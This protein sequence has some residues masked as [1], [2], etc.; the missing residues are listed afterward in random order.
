MIAKLTMTVFALV[1]LAATADDSEF[2]R[3]SFRNLTPA[4]R[5]RLAADA[6]AGRGWKAHNDRPAMFV[7]GQFFYGLE[8]SD[9]LHTWYER[10][11]H[12]D[13]SLQD[14]NVR[15][16]RINPQSWKRN[17]EIARDMNLDGF[18]FFPSN[19]GCWD[20]LPRSQMSGGE[21]TILP[22]LHNGDTGKGIEHC[23]GVLERLLKEAP[24]CYRLGDRIVITCYPPMVPPWQGPQLEFWA[25]LKAAAKE[26]FGGDRFCF[27]PY[28]YIFDARDLDRPESDVAF[29]EHTEANVRSALR[30]T[31]GLFYNLTESDWAPESCLR[32][33]HDSIVIPIVKKVMSEPEFKDKYLGIGYWQAHE[34]CYRRFAD[35]LSYGF[36]RLVSALRSIEAA[37]PDFAIAFEWD[38]ENENTHFRPTVSNGQ[39]TQRILR[40]CADRWAGTK[41]KPYPTD[42]ATDV[43]NLAVAYR[44]SLEC[45]EKLSVQ[46]LNI[47]DGTARDAELEVSFRWKSATGKVVREFS[48]Q[49]LRTDKLELV[50]FECPSEELV[51]EHLLVPELVVSGVRTGKRVFNEGFWPLALEANRNVDSK[52]VRQAL[53]ELVPDV[54]AQLEVGAEAADGTVEVRGEIAG[55]VKFRSVEVLEGSDTVYMH[56]PSEPKGRPDDEQVTVA[57]TFLAQPTFWKLHSATGFIRT[58]N[59]PH[60][61]HRDRIPNF[62]RHQGPDCCFNNTPVRFNFQNTHWIDIPMAEAD[63]AVVEIHIPE[64]MSVKRIP[65]RELLRDGVYAW[66]FDGGGQLAVRR[67]LTVRTIPRPIMADS[68]K[69]SFRMKRRNPLS[70]LRLQAIDEHYRIWRG[71]GR[72]WV[73]PSGRSVAYHVYSDSERRGVE[74]RVDAA[75]LVS[76]KWD[77]RDAHGDVWYPKGGWWDLPCAGGGGVGTVTGLGSGDNN[78]YSYCL[79]HVFDDL[80]EADGTATTVP[81]RVQEPDGSCALRFAG[82][83]FASLPLN[84]NPRQSGFSIALK[85]WPD[86]LNGSQGLFDSGNIGFSMTLEDGVPTAFVCLAPEMYRRGVNDT[87]GLKV[88]G[89]RLKAGQWNSLRFVFDQ[90]SAWIEVDGVAG[91]SAKGCG[92][93]RNSGCMAFGM[94]VR[95]LKPFH[96]KLSDLTLEPR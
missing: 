40:Y 2:V 31:D 77:F 29:I 32:M 88:R 39:T 70:V 14:A 42:Q 36:E 23:L 96:G 57:I 74:V 63:L 22:E 91:E 51:A 84:F 38:E 60:A 26:R 78:G 75:R 24:N 55:P 7:R 73:S 85:V 13:S 12:Q 83:S 87:A 33:P 6:E 92:N 58:V 10:P 44:K 4:A 1:S 79:N 47:P 89:P 69:F 76:L 28:A 53:R 45:G 30:A 94:F 11:L 95:G 18:A 81:V 37:R 25:K 20:V 90:R 59:A 21:I 72:D 48:A 93:S 61:E 66:A 46:V 68:V 56:D 17:V 54:K 80:R 64:V 9:Y 5:A 16:S 49:R 82:H 3:K 67:E 19:P 27:M 43:P 52:W 86:D 8:R 35:K 50:R 65:V 15:G 62:V 41:L 71:C 34:N